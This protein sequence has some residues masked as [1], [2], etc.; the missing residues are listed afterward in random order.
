MHEF[1]EVQPITVQSKALDLDIASRSELA[2]TEPHGVCQDTHRRGHHA[3]TNNAADVTGWVP[4]AATR[5]IE[6]D[7]VTFV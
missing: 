4:E 5:R 1:S 6:H 2:F 7:L 3:M